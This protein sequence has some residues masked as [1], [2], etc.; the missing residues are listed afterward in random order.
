MPVG[1]GLPVHLQVTMTGR[2]TRVASAA[3]V[4]DGSLVSTD[5]SGVNCTP[6]AWSLRHTTRH[7]R[8]KLLES[9]STNM[10]GNALASAVANR[11]PPSETS[12]SQ[13]RIISP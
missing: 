6:T 2:L 13:Q 12:D 3:V 8:L 5:T 4:F 11:A 7:H 1:I 9:S 10:S